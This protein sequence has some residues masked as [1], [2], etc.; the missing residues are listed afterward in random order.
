MNWRAGGVMLQHMPKSELRARGEGGSGE[1]GL[2]AAEDL[3]DGDEGEN[4]RRPTCCSTRSTS[5][6]CRPA[7]VAHGPSGA[8]VPRG[9]AA[10]L[11]CAAGAVRLHLFGGSRAQSLSIYSAKDIAHMTTDEGIVTADCQFCGAHY[12]FDPK[13]LGFEAV[14]TARRRG[15][16]HRLTS[17]GCIAGEACRPPPSSDFDLNPGVVLPPGR[18]LRPA[19]VLIPVLGAEVILTKRASHLKHHPGQIALP[20]GKVDEGDAGPAAAALREARE[21]IG[22]D[23]GERGRVWRSC[24]PMRR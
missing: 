17:T 4:W 15:W 2:L 16:A 20:G 10:R 23:P 22:L 5:W 19:A 11:R 24:R 6:S 21:E 3:I 12:E 18:K 1:D 8:P 14:I 13:T 9:N 7:R